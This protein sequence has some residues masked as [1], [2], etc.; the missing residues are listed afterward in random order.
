MNSAFDKRVAQSVGVTVAGLKY[1]AKLTAGERTQRR[2]ATQRGNE[3]TR[4]A[5]HGH[6]VPAGRFAGEYAL[7]ETG[8]DIVRRAR[9]MGW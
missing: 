8:R 2:V 3:A 6:V 5:A 1:L 9:A 4:L 7:T